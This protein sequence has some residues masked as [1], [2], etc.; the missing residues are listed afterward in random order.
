MQS[1]TISG[2]T[3][4]TAR[5][6]SIAVT[7]AVTKASSR[8]WLFLVVGLRQAHGCQQRVKRRG[9]PRPTAERKLVFELFGCARLSSRAPLLFFQ[10]FA[11][12]GQVGTIAPK[13]RA[14]EPARSRYRSAPG[15]RR[16]LEARRKRSQVP[17][18]PAV[19][20]DIRTIAPCVLN[21]IFFVGFLCYWYL[22]IR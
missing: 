12:M 1:W 7:V 4:R 13:L 11:R 2:H 21:P 19:G 5:G 20:S 6:T 15:C 9:C 16:S 18:A 17:T 10:A 22:F 14:S 8:A 3:Q